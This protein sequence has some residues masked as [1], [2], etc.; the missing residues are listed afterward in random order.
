LTLWT[1]RVAT[2]LYVVAMAGWLARW[3]RLS[4]VTWTVA[5][6]FYLAHVAAAFHFYH[7]W[8]HS[9]A[10]RETARQTAEVFGVNWGGGLYFNYAFTAIWVAD[11]LWWWRGLTAYRLRAR[12]ITA[13]IH[14]FFAFMFFNATVIFARGWTRWFG[15]FATT[16]LF[17]LW[18]RTNRSDRLISSG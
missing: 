4:R 3:D 5:C 12:W 17:G 11:V 6:A 1:I 2:L 16:V 13:S 9:A 15:V 10:Y 14:L 18:W 8:S 7:G